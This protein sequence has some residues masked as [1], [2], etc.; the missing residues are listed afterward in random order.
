M[1]FE[2]KDTK[3]NRYTMTFIKKK[4]EIPSV[5]DKKNIKKAKIDCFISYFLQKFTNFAAQKT[6][7]SIYN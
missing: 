7:G 4:S 3:K 5:S 2:V 6:I 1:S